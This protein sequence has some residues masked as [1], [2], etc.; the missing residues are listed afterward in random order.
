[1]HFSGAISSLLLTVLALLSSNVEAKP[2]SRRNTTDLAPIRL[3]H[4][5][6]LGSWVEN[7]AVRANGQLLVTM[8][9]VPDLYLIDPTTNEMALV[10]SFPEVIGLAAITEVQPDVFAGKHPSFLFYTFSHLD[11][12]TSTHLISDSKNRPSSLF[13]AKAKF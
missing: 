4:E 7:M 12:N 1:M 2:L 10:A 9:T 6:P 8:L 13:K 3:I 11:A 5:F